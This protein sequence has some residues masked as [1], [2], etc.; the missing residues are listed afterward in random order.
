MYSSHY[1]KNK[2]TFPR[3]Q[4]FEHITE[5]SRRTSYRVGPGCYDFKVGTNK[6]L[7]PRFV[8]EEVVRPSKKW[9][10]FFVGDSI[11]RQERPDSRA[12][13]RSLSAKRGNETFTYGSGNKYDGYSPESGEKGKKFS[14][15]RPQSSQDAR[16]DLQFGE[17]HSGKKPGRD[18]FNYNGHSKTKPTTSHLDDP[19]LYG[20][21]DLRKSLDRGRPQSGHKHRDHD[22]DRAGGQ[23]VK[24]EIIN[25]IFVTYDKQ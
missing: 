6:G 22:F 10:Y 2:S 9:D 12:K 23:D 13:A 8:K 18:N 15:R 25:K 20:K 7:G 21:E 16:R 1:P 17:E 11:V 24:K 5:V 14:G 19:G 4:R 3:G